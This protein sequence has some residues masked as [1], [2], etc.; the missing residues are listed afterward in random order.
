MSSPQATD[1]RDA[2]RIA[3]RVA[4]DGRESRVE[5]RER[6]PNDVI[7]KLSHRFGPAIVLSKS[8][9]CAISSDLPLVRGAV[10]DLNTRAAWLAQGATV[11]P[12]CL[13]FPLP[14]FAASSVVSN[15]QSRG[16]HH[17]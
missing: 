16:Q 5:A 2:A 17:K 13:S 4:R 10:P 11:R 3:A 1:G 14:L 6:A 15:G 9:A 8:S 12:D 7:E